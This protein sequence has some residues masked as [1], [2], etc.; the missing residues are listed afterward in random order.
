MGHLPFQRQLSEFGYRFQ[1][2]TLAGFHALNLSAFELAYEYAQSG[3]SHI[4]R[5]QEREFQVAER[6]G[7]GAT[8]HQRFV[9][10]GYFDDVAN[11]IT[12][13]QT[14]IRALPGSTEEEQFESPSD[15]KS[16]D[17]DFLFRYR[18]IGKISLR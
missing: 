8:R 13:G 10:T 7:Y 1:F 11:T 9:G 14:S 2:V 5:L 16:M 6:V 18:A 17:T 4:Q 3:M 15:G 12:A